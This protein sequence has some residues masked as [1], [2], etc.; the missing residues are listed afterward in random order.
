M[1]I[2]QRPSAKVLTFCDIAKQYGDFFANG[3]R[4]TV[5]KAEQSAPCP[6]SFHVA[7]SFFKNIF[8][9]WIKFSSHAE[10]SFSARREKV[11]CTQRKSYLHA[12]KRLSACREYQ[13]QRQWLFEQIDV[14]IAVEADFLSVTSAAKHFLY[15]LLLGGQQQFCAILVLVVGCLAAEICRQLDADGVQVLL[16][17]FGEEVAEADGGAHLAD[18]MEVGALVVLHGGGQ[19]AEVAGGA[20]GCKQMGLV[21]HAL[22]TAAALGDVADGPVEGDLLEIDVV[23]HVFRMF[24]LFLPCKGMQFLGLFVYLCTQNHKKTF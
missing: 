11:I 6:T 22:V 15:P 9:V 8:P 21:A 10:K 5:A 3:R 13:K 19:D 23:V 14:L 20:A 17:Q 16:L 24:W 4:G 1:H 12:E 7:F 2:S 18:G